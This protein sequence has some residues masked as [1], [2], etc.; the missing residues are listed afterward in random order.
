MG[1]FFVNFHILCDSAAKVRDALAPLV[2]SAAYVSP[3]KNGCVIVYEKA[4]DE[5]D[6]E[7]IRQIGSELSRALNTAVLSF[8]VHD[9]DIAMYWL[10]QSGKLVDEFNSAPD[11]YVK[12][13]KAER[14]Q[15]SGNAQALL[16][17][18]VSGT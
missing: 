15:T 1:A 16:P 12:V 7:I 14:A 13:S 4:S 6:D 9:S 10:F 3:P 11:Y 18:C 2:Q 17:L 8:L 5:Q